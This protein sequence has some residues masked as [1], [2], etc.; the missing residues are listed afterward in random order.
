MSISN[1]S[2]HAEPTTAP[3]PTTTTEPTTTAPTTTVAPPS[4]TY[5]LQPQEI[6]T[7]F[8]IMNAPTE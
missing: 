5:T 7:F 2:T 6:K 3:T 8:V 4:F 1:T